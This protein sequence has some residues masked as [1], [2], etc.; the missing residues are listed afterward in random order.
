MALQMEA[1]PLDI[2]PASTVISGG[3]KT[4]ESGRSRV[5]LAANA[6]ALATN[7]SYVDELRQVAD[8]QLPCGAHEEMGSETIVPGRRSF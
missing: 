4:R 3:A 5:G 2:A 1:G 7:D 6:W 8:I